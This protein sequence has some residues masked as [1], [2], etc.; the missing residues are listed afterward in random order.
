MPE[1]SA[2]ASI[3][4]K[5]RWYVP[6][7]GKF[8]AAV[9][10]I[11]GVL[12]LSAHYRWFWFNE[13]K[14]YT[15]LITFAASAFLLL[16]LVGWVGI[17]RFFKTRQQFGL[18]T[19][20][21][22][23]PVMAIPCGWLAH[24][25]TLAREQRDFAAKLHSRGGWVAYNRGSSF[26]LVPPFLRPMTRQKLES[27]LGDDYF[28]DVTD[29]TMYGAEDHDLTFIAR[30]SQLVS[31]QNLA[32]RDGDAARITDAGLEHLRG[33]TRLKHL[34]LQKA[35]ITDQGL[36]RIGGLTQLEGLQIQDSP[37]ITESGLGK[38]HR[39]TGLKTLDLTNASITDAGLEHIKEFTQ[40][41]NLWIGGN[42]LTDDGLVHLKTLTKLETLELRN[43]P[44]SDVG[45]EHLQ[46]LK[47]LRRLSIKGTLITNPGARV[48]MDAVRGCAID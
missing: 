17:S 42:Q 14:G 3:S 46:S 44:V 9:L 2:T 8:L 16:L 19:L 38:L 23:V 6:T 37:R 12:Y 41:I 25:L 11:Q 40:L 13:R 5:P 18:A 28:R 27:I 34:S 4:G 31:L 36:E 15:V 33:L 26:D 1:T 45:L 32:S 47:Q 43:M 48:F 20:L 29:V 10:L 24:E 21:L 30:F 22:I 39:L 7:P 35:N